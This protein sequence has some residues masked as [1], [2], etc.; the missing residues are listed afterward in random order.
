MTESVKD[1][2]S[3]EVGLQASAGIFAGDKKRACCVSEEWDF[4]M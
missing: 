1:K 3:S 2:L 4:P